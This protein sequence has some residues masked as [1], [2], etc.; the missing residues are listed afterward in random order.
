MALTYIATVQT[1]AVDVF[2]KN[3]FSVVC[4]KYVARI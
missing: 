4:D 3:G 2:A 1:R